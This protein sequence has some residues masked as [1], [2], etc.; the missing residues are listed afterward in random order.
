ME[1]AGD[2][3]R[4]VIR[5][6]AKGTTGIHVSHS[7]SNIN[8]FVT[9]LLNS[10]NLLEVDPFRQS[11]SD[12]E[13]VDRVIMVYNL[14]WRK[15]TQIDETKLA[16]PGTKKRPDLGAGA[17]CM[18]KGVRANTKKRFES[19]PGVDIGDIFFFRFELC[20]VG[21]H[22]PSIAGIDFMGVPS[23]EYEEPVAVS[24]VS[25][26]GYEDEGDDGEV[27]I[28]SGAGGAQRKDKPQTDQQLTRGNLALEKSLH[29]G[30]KVRVIRGIKDC[31]YTTGKVYLYDGLYTIHESWIEKEKSGC[32]VFKYKLFRVPGQPEAFT[33]W[34]SIQQWKKSHGPIT[35]V[36]VNVILPDLSSRAEM[37][38]VSL[39]NDVD[40][41]KGPASFT[42]TR[43]L[44]Y[45]NPFPLTKSSST[46]TCTDGCQPGSNCP[47]L[48][49][50]GGYMPYTPLG[51]LLTH[52][53]VI[54]ECG[55]SCRC[56]NTCRNRIS[57]MG[58]KIRLEV[59]KTKDRGWGLRSWDPI[60]SGGFICEYAGVVI[61][62]RKGID[63]D[64]DYVFDATRVF[65]P[66]ESVTSDEHAKF[67][68]PLVISA[69]KEGNV[70]RFM[71]H[72]CS[73]NVYWQPVVCEYQHD[74]YFHVGFYAIKHIPPMQELTYSYGK[75][76]V[77]KGGPRRKKC[78]CGSP[79]C[80]GS[81][82]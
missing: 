7:D 5:K 23:S 1:T 56:L 61:E 37:L 47:C 62:G 70:G 64:D 73:P 40:D 20:L 2:D 41:E 43:T 74:A 60:R 34:K 72:S 65:E 76:R 25:A 48:Q 45:K 75:G 53:T 67:P 11:D 3:D 29:R 50:N 27:L 13:L 15:L 49:K 71:N 18:N 57:Q 19:V 80:K 36:G 10:F 78:L 82:Y 66:V 30:D 51:V 52:N 4:S 81:F 44:K 28:Y 38:P 21:L 17:I 35:R 46:C 24:I 22:F 58:L 33:L 8:S 26:G 16:L 42:Y 69:K 68:F 55:N 79:R 32:D 9:N 31:Q 77:D 63:P 14:L 54:H 12:K 59:F 39:V 6:K